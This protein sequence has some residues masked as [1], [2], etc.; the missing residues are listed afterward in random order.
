MFNLKTKQLIFE[1]AGFLCEYCLT[2][3]AFSSQPFVCEHIIP[4]VKNGTNELDNLAAACGG[5]NGH[6]KYTKTEALDPITRT[7]VPLYS[8]RKMNWAGH[9]MWSADFLNIIGITDIGRATVHT[10][11]LNRKGVVNIRRVLLIDGSHPAQ[12]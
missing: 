8:P 6:N 9:F 10:L 7:V 3:I 12:K 5:C 1:R 4:T 11:Y 2:P